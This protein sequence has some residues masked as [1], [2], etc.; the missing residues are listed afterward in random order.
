VV[1][2]D[3]V[4]EQTFPAVGGCVLPVADPL[5]G[6]VRPVR[7]TRREARDRARANEERLDGLAQLFVE[8]GID[9]LVL[10]SAEPADV[11][12]RFLVWADGRRTGWPR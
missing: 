5:T 3:P 2:Q 1:V 6:A 11:L 10:A 12:D 8:L 7:L 9:Q 4:W